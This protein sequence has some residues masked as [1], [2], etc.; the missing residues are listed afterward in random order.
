[1]N[2]YIPIFRGLHALGGR[3]L[4][5]DTHIH[6]RDNYS[7]PRCAHAR[8]GLIIPTQR[9]YSGFSANQGEKLQIQAVEDVDLNIGP[10]RRLP[11]T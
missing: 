3:K 10:S 9:V 11:T 4:R 7:N 2:T 1:M 8:R 6:T 5:T